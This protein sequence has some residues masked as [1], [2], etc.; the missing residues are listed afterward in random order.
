MMI[1]HVP[2]APGY[3][4]VELRRRDSE[5]SEKFIAYWVGS[6]WDYVLGPDEEIVAVSFKIYP[7]IM[8]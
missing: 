2:N 5:P 4:W 8:D 1:E 3:Y 7:A 6:F